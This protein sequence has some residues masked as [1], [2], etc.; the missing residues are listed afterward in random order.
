MGA[1]AEVDTEHIFQPVTAS[2]GLTDNSA[3]TIKCTLTGR[4]TIT[5]LGSINFY[6]GGGFTQ[7]DQADEMLY[8]LLDYKGHYHLY[9]DNNHHLW[10]KSSRGVSCVNL[11]SERYESNMDSL[12]AT[13]GAKGRVH[14]L[15]IDANGDVWLSDGR[16]IFNTKYRKKVQLKKGRN[17]Q[18]LEVFNKQQLLLFY[19]DGRL[20]CYDLKGGRK[21]YEN[22]A[23]GPDD[24]ARYADSGVQLTYGDGIFMIRNGKESGILM[25]YDIMARRWSEVLRGEGHLNNMKVYRDKLYIA[26]EWGYYTYH[27]ITHE[28]IYYKTLTLKSGRLLDTDIN[29]IEFDHQGGM[30]LGTE[31]RGLLYSGPLNANFR[32]LSWSDPQSA[33]Y[34]EQMKDLKGISEFRGKKANVF[35]VDSRK[36]TWV[37]TPNGLYLYTTPQAE[38]VVF[39]KG[40]GFLNSVIHTVIEDNFNN[41]WASTSYGISC[42]RIKDG[43]VS[44]VF[45][46]SGA[47]NVPN[48]TFINAKAIKMPSG[49]IAMQALDHVVVFDPRNFMSVFEPQTYVMNTKLTR[50]MVNGIDVRTG[51]EIDGEVILKK[52][53]SRI[54]E[55]DLNYNQ[56]SIVLTFSALNYARPLQT[57]YRVKIEELNDEW[58]EFSYFDG[59]GLVDKRGLLHLP[60]SGLKPGTYH[61]K[62][63]ASVGPDDFAGQ[64]YEWVVNIHTPWWSTTGVIAGVGV[65]LLVLVVLNFMA[66]NHNIRLK[67]RR[68]NEEGDLIRRI[69]AFVNRSDGF[70]SERLS[71]TQEEIYGQDSDSQ[72][73]L[74]PEFVDTMLKIIPYVHEREGRP[75]TMHMLSEVT[76]LDL[77][78][79][80]EQCTENLHKSPRAL[81]RSMRVDQVADMLKTT[82][83]TI[84][85]ISMACGFV[86]PNYMISRFFHKFRMTPLEYRRVIQQGGESGEAATEASPADSLPAASSGH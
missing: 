85:E 42:L 57:Y 74:S 46:F 44:Q 75:F 78:D 62:V 1:R 73:E 84:E 16:H 15:F 47:D 11:T 41:I 29:A 51:M 54:R 86:S 66:F 8:A 9:Y 55:I 3:Q 63:Q 83:K 20:C 49:E 2:D 34:W 4:M 10:L 26:S 22:H 81:I 28:T 61:I 18:D 56:N 35:M 37:G 82:D 27:L 71:P 36:W 38:P 14:D 69:V 30:W 17:L 77:L 25:H 19:D 53:I 21:L 76:G 68:N 50:L 23:Y 60:M 52:A 24:A 6:D 43:E 31:Q 45:C 48:E 32:S 65:I 58:Q 12:F 7:I 33:Y 59:N 39:S 13:Y 40:N 79:L 72:S 5:T 64:P 70:Y 67:M 80:Y